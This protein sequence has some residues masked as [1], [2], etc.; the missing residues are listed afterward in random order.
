MNAAEFN[1]GYT[2]SGHPVA[3]AVALENL[4]ILQ[5]ENVLDHVRNVAMPAFDQ[6]LKSLTDHPLVG[7]AKSAGLMGSIALTPNKTTRAAFAADKGTAGYL[8]RERCFAN[9]IIMRHVGDRMVLSPPLVIS[10][11]ELK[12]LFTRVRKALDE[13]L[14]LLKEKDLLHAA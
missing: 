2:Y 11:A 13:T 6:G 5:E 7:E 10:E 8:C 9:N 4:R 12:I 14:A 3:A 1:H